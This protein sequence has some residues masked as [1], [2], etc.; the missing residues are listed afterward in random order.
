MAI[1]M[2][3]FFANIGG[4]T[5]DGWLGFW[6]GY[7]GSIVAI[8]GI[9]W[10]VTRS[11]RHE[12]THN[13]E[14]VR[15]LLYFSYRR[16][17]NKGE[18]VYYNASVD[19][20]INIGEAKF[21]VPLVMIEGEHESLEFGEQYRYDPKL[22]VIQNVSN[23]DAYFCSLQVSYYYGE[24]TDREVWGKKNFADL[25]KS[26]LEEEL[27]EEHI[28]FSVLDAKSSA[29][30][31]IWPILL[32]RFARIKSVDMTFSTVYEKGRAHIGLMDVK[33]ENRNVDIQQVPKYTYTVKKPGD[34]YY[35]DKASY[36][37]FSVVE[38]A[39]IG[40]EILKE[41][42]LDSHGKNKVEI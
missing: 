8:F 14:S 10:E 39:P 22:L 2:Q 30:I 7:L 26:K 29:I 17:L 11:E 28:E 33:K 6:G 18:K 35:S 9:Y 12:Y 41:Y 36:T 16:G 24:E 27:H 21:D 40:S 3:T 42:V 38:A 1:L 4:G 13:S 31:A 20:W 15:P 19:Q 25:D 5:D 34:S 23:Q 37:A 32:H